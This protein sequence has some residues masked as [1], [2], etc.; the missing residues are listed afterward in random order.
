MQFKASSG[1]LTIG[2]FSLKDVFKRSGIFFSLLNSSIKKDNLLFEFSSTDW[3]LE[4]SSTWVMAGTKDC[5]SFSY[6]NHVPYSQKLVSE[7]TCS[8][9]TEQSRAI[10]PAWTAR[11]LEQTNWYILP[12]NPQENV[13]Y[14]FENNLNTTIL[15][16]D[17]FVPKYTCLGT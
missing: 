9:F 10:M 4:V 12:L 7:K 1:F 2:S 8:V 15:E 14:P 16:K 6:K 3:I 11:D 5:L 17:Y 13:C